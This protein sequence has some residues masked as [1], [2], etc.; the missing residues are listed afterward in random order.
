MAIAA[1]FLRWAAERH[2]D[3]LARAGLVLLAE[4][5]EAVDGD[6]LQRWQL[7]PEITGSPP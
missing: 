3:E 2:P 5:S 1:P 4:L 6:L 7:L